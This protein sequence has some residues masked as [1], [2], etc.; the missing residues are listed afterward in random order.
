MPWQGGHDDSAVGA[1]R[2][3]HDTN[4]ANVSGGNDIVA[5]EEAGRDAELGLGVE[6]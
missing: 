5:T 3:E 2:W 6:A 4:S 1:A